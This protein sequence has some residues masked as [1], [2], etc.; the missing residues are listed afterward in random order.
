MPANDARQWLSALADGEREAAPHGLTAWRDDPEARRQWHLYHLIG[1]VLRSDDLATAPRR[2]AQFVAR[3]REQLAHEPVPLA[4]VRARRLGWRAPVAVAAG[5]VAV[6]ATLVVIRPQGLGLGGEQL[7]AE[8]AS[9]IAAPPSQRPLVS[10]SPAGGPLVADGPM[11]RDPRL[12]AYLQAH[13]AA[14][15]AAPAALPFGGLRN[16]EVVVV[17]ALPPRLQ[18]SPAASEAMPVL[19]PASEAR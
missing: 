2:D 4:P 17:P 7:V 1:D 14:R 15:G 9:N 10:S 19:R 8:S 5:F 16:A 13:Q 12:N 6:A 3:L 11:L 18:V